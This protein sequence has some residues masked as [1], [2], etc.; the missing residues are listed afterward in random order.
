[1]CIV[2]APMTTCDGRASLTTSASEILSLI[3][4][5]HR[6][7]VCATFA[8]GRPRAKQV[9]PNSVSRVVS[10]RQSRTRAPRAIGPATA[11]VEANLH[12]WRQRQTSMDGGAPPWLGM[13]QNGLFTI[14]FGDRPQAVRRSRALASAIP[15]GIPTDSTGAIGSRGHSF[16]GIAVSPFMLAG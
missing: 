7:H 11:W 2:D 1:L 12:G 13:R 16:V 9:S 15:D 10:A 8:R 3:A 4:D 5:G 14:P 6:A